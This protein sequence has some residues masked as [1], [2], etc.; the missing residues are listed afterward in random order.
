MV[1]RH[2]GRILFASLL[3]LAANGLRAQSVSRL[4]SS[5]VTFYSSAPL[6]D[7]EATNKKSSGVV[8]WTKRSFLISIPIRGF[9]FRSGMMQTH[10]NENY[11]ESDKYPDCTYRGTF[12]GA[13]D[14]TKDGDY[15][16]VTTGDLTLHGVTKK[17]SIPAT[18][19]VRNGSVTVKSKFDIRVADHKIKI[20]KW[21]LRRSLKWWPSPSTGNS[22]PDS[23]HKTEKPLFNGGAFLF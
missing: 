2:L 7:I 9:E 23:L 8:D 13:V 17:R 16:I 6:E 11:L 19:S 3:L 21:F 20:P 14:L 10:F 4:Q 12:T 15:P 5:V 22:L 18:L 1:N